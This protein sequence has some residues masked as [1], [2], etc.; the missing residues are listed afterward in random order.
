MRLKDIGRFQ[1]TQKRP[2]T[3][4]TREGPLVRSQYRPPCSF[5]FSPPPTFLV[6]SSSR[7]G[8]F[9]GPVGAPH[10]ALPRSCNTRQKARA[11]ARA[12]HLWESGTDLLS[13]GIPRAIIGAAPFHGRHSYAHFSRSRMAR[14]ITQFLS[15]SDRKES[16]SVKWVM[17]WRQD[18]RVKE[19]LVRS[20]PQ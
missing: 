14:P 1:W 10:E 3:P 20:V 17:R 12:F 8:Q 15:L 7:Q 4:L 13:R 18:T 16:S 9:L 2:F 11:C 6:A 19:V 5:P